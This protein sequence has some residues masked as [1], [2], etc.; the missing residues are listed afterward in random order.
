MAATM[1]EYKIVVFS[2]NANGAQAAR[3]CLLLSRWDIETLRFALLDDGPLFFVLTQTRSLDSEATASRIREAA[4][5]L[6]QAIRETGVRPLIVSR[7][8]CA[9]RGHHAVETRELS[10][11]LGP[12]DAHLVVPEL[13]DDNAVQCGTVSGSDAGHRGVPEHEARVVRD[14]LYAGRYNFLADWLSE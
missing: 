8:D 3:G 4:G 10:A 5:N 12:F 6:N 11:A 7:T 9:L 14:T 2:E 1:S 13:I